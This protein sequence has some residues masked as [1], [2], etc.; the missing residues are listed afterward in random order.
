MIGKDGRRW[1]RL[2]VYIFLEHNGKI[3]L[4]KRKNA[5]G[6]GYYST[7]AGHIDPGETVLECA[8]RELLEETGI[9][10][11]YFEFIGVRLIGDYE[12]KGEKAHEYIA[13]AVK[14]K[15]WNGD[16]KLMEPNK[17]ERWEWY[18]INN[19]PK[20]MFPPVPMLIECIKKS[21]PFVD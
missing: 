14:P 20:P 3:L 8:N 13:F 15:N 5:F 16:P 21:V 4:G 18:S 6:E 17:I 7:P 2:V 19:L 11:K 10:A 1:V 12:I 9:Y